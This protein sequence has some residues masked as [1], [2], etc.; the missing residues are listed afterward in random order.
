MPMSR[1]RI[2]MGAWWE[3]IR[4]LDLSW[5]KGKV[6]FVFWDGTLQV[7]AISTSYPVP[8]AADK[9][10]VGLRKQ[11]EQLIVMVD[12]TQ[13]GQVADPGLFPDNRAYLGANV[14]PYSKLVIHDISVEAV[15]GKES[16]VRI[17]SP[18][19]TAA[20]VPSTPALRE[21]AQARGIA[22]GAAVAPGPLR[23]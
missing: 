8:G 15:R 5:S 12:G 20:Y 16:T 7:P 14:R 13:V 11:G 22:I 4:R 17:V 21:L 6:G 2:V 9:A 18:T 23:C 1:W 19:D 10:R 3:G